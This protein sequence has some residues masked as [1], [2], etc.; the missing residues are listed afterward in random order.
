LAEAARRTIGEG[1]EKGLI[2][3][4]D[5]AEGLA[6][7]LEAFDDQVGIGFFHWA[8]CMYIRHIAN[9]S[10]ERR[11]GDKE[12]TPVFRAFAGQVSTKKAAMATMMSTKIKMQACRIIRAI[13]LYY[14]I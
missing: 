3:G 4:H 7:A 10:P 12:K 5:V 13:T 1:A 9:K 2:P 14:R 8:Y 6:T 11:E